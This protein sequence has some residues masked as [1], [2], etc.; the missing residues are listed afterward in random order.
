MKPPLTIKQALEEL[1]LAYERHI[2]NLKAEIV[3]KDKTKKS[4]YDLIKAKEQLREVEK[5]VL[6]E[7]EIIK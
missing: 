7:Q 5:E 3:I 1:S 2:N 6:Q 4:Y